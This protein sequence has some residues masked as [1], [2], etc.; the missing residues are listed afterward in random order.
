MA[1]THTTPKEIAAALARDPIRLCRR[2]LPHG[3]QVG[4]EWCV[5]SIDG[6]EGQSLK[7][8]C[9]GEKAG[10]WADFSGNDKGDL[11]DLIAARERVSLGKAII[12]AKEFLGIQ[13]F[14]SVVKPKTYKALVRPPNVKAVKTGPVE[15]YMTVNRK[16][17]PE[18]IKAYRVAEHGREMAFPS[19]SQDGEL[20][21]IKY[22]SI[23]RDPK[24]KKMVR[25]EAGCPPALFGWQ[26]MPPGQ[27]EAI[28]TEGQIDAMTWF[29]LGF[30][31][32]S[33]PD[34]VGNL[35]GWI[36][37]EWDNLQRFDTIYLNFDNDKAGQEAV[38]KVAERLGKSRC[39]SVTLKQKD[40]N[41]A[42]VAGA[43]NLDFA[44][45]A[46][47]GKHFTPNE[48]KQPQDFLDG[49]IDK[50]YPPNGEP[51]GFF[52]ELLGK[53]IGFRPGEVTIW[54][55]ISSHGKSAMLSQV[56]LD[57]MDANQRVAIASMEMTGV[58][59][60]YRMTCQKS[61]K[62]IPTR[63]EIVSINKWMS[64]RLWIFD[65]LGNVETEKLDELMDYAFAR[66]NVNHFVIDSLMK[67]SV[68][69]EDYDAQRNFLNQLTGF[70]LKTG[71]HI[72]LV[73]H[74]RKGRDESMS[75]GKMDVAGSG[76]IINQADNILSVWRNKDKEANV[77]E[78]KLSE[79]QEKDT[80]DT[81]VFCMKQRENGVEF[82]M[83]LLFNNTT[84]S[85]R[86]HF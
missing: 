3:K 33:M 70:A 10:V 86:R 18:T 29:Q 44:R 28:I 58:Q 38:A 6:E 20:L 4:A 85:F 21:N 77:R 80:P 78:G 64:G 76:N 61:S 83:P 2:L 52:P 34:G 56:M 71:A 17:T 19:F 7:V 27:R 16:L 40:A 82:E 66:F 72:H 30:P 60:L 69:S 8:R 25:Q 51:V 43:T 24:G 55:G 37:Y 62:S 42:L 39:I 11:L 23:D 45:A 47:N 48:I 32:L 59:T 49:V 84:Y 46:I 53:K 35:D 50:F 63:E 1:V 74:A 75:P 81:K 15:E 65:I 12:W 79:E 13:T 41:D 54:T 57:A 14:T 31:A 22:I 9:S 36:D 68:G 73:A 67:V 26:A 5:G